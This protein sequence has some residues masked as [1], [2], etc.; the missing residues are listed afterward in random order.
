MA[1]GVD[2]KRIPLSRAALVLLIC[3]AMSPISRRVSFFSAG[4]LVSRRVLLKLCGLGLTALST[5]AWRSRASTT[6]LAVNVPAGAVGCVLTPELT[7]GPYYIA[8]EKVRSNITEHRPGIPLTLRLTVVDASTCAPLR[9]A[10]VDIWHCDASGV[11]SGFEQASTGSTAGGGG[12][13]GNGGPSPGGNSGPPP[14]GNGGPPPGGTS[15]PTDKDTFLRGIQ[16]TNA[17]GIATFQTIYP[18]WY[19]GRTVHIHVKVHVGGAVVHTGQLFFPDSLTDKVYQA[20]APYRTRAA[21]RDTRNATDSIY[22]NGGPRSM[23]ALTRTRAG[24]F[25]GAITLGVRRT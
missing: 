22:Q 18:G 4:R 14:G 1:D 17:R 13:G 12:S 20:T 8:R 19:T 3:V 7:E 16:P 9:G 5:L 11:Y 21:R 2:M 23:L 10:A 15:K 25:T 24:G 6:R